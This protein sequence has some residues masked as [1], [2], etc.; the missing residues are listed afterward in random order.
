M[1]SCRKQNNGLYKC[2]EWCQIIGARKSFYYVN[3]R[4]VIFEERNMPGL[5]TS[6]INVLTSN[7]IWQGY[8][9]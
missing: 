1:K 9:L 3:Q 7:L 2:T 4:R 5:S 8:Q 6:E